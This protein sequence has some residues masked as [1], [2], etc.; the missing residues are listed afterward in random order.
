M[1]MLM[2]EGSCTIKFVSMCRNYNDTSQI[3]ININKNTTYV[4]LSNILATISA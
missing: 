2:H 1:L 4:P 3:I